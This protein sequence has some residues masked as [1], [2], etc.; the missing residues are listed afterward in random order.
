MD[1]TILSEEDRRKILEWNSHLPD[2]VDALIHE[3]FTA[4]AQRS[5]DAPAIC[6]WDGE[7]NYRDLDR[8]STQLAHHFGDLGVQPEQNH[9]VAIHLPKC[10]WVPVLALAILKAGGICLT[11][12]ISLPPNRLRTVLSQA[13]PRFVCSRSREASTI[14]QGETITIDDGFFERLS[15]PRLNARLPSLVSSRTAYLIFTSGSTGIPKAVLI[16]HVNMCTA[17]QYQHAAMGI[18]ATSRVWDFVSCAFDV[19]YS[20]LFQTLT[21]GACLCIPSEDD[22]VQ[23]PARSVRKLRANYAHITPTI[24]RLLDPSDVP[25]LST[26]NFIGEP[27]TRSDV[28]RWSARTIYNTWGPCECTPVSSIA[29]IDPNLDETPHVGIGFGAVTWVI[30]Q[31]S[32]ELAAIGQ[33]GE[34]VVEG[35]LVGKG[36]LNDPGK[37][38]AAFIPNPVWLPK[39]LPESRLH[40]TFYRTGDLAFYRED[41]NLQ[42]V[43]RSD[44]QIKIAGVR[45]EL[46]EVETHLRALLPQQL[47]VQVTAEKVP[48]EN[49]SD[50]RLVAFFTCPTLTKAELEE[51]LETCRLNDELAKSLPSAMLPSTYVALDAMPTTI[52]GKADRLSLRKIGA[53][54]LAKLIQVRRGDIPSTSEELEM[55]SL[56]QRVLHLKAEDIRTQ[57]SFLDL[58]GSSVQAIRLA[59]EARKRGFELHVGDIL[60]DPRF[61]SMASVLRRSTMHEEAIAP[62]SL[63]PSDYGQSVSNIRQQVAS[64]CSIASEDIT[65]VYPTTSLQEA[66]LA[67]STKRPGDYVAHLEATL[68]DHIDVIHFREAWQNLVAQTPILRTRIINLDG[69]PRLYQVVVQNDTELVEIGL[70]QPDTLESNNTTNIGVGT[71][72][73]KAFLVQNGGIRTFK[74]TISHVI[75][76]GWSISLLLNALSRLY[77]DHSDVPAPSFNLFIKH[78]TDIDY[79]AAE[80]F[81]KQHFADLEAPQFPMLPSPSH[82]VY[83]DQTFARSFNQLR[84]QGSRFTASTLI[85]AAYALLISNYTSH[86]LSEALF[87]AVVAGRQVA[88]PGIESIIGPTFATIPIRIKIDAF[89]TVAHFLES[90]QQGAIATM[91]FEQY[92]LQNIAKLSTEAVQGCQFQSL[93]VV[94][95]GV[96]DRMTSCDL[97]QED[98]ADVSIERISAFST[99]ALTIQCTLQGSTGLLVE[100]SFDSAVVPR[101]QVEKLVAQLGTVLEQLSM[102]T[103]FAKRVAD[104]ATITNEDVQTIQRWNQIELE[105]SEYCIHD[106]IIENAR[107]FPNEEAVCSWDGSL[108]YHQLDEL[109]LALAMHLADIG[110]RPGVAV[111]LCFEKSKWMPV[112]QL[113]IWRA[114][115]CCV[116]LDTSQPLARLRSIVAQV[117]PIVV[118]SSVSKTEV[119][120]KLTDT[121]VSTVSVDMDMISRLHH[122]KLQY[123][124]TSQPSDRLY[125]VYVYTESQGDCFLQANFTSI[126]FTSGSTGEPKGVIISHRNFAYQ[127]Q[128]YGLGREARVLDFSSYAWDAALWNVLYTL[129]VGGCLCEFQGIGNDLIWWLTRT[130]YSI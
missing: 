22:R 47:G 71:Q 129:A 101:S 34:L 1:T 96:E 38:K 35:P 92:G 67:S 62:F 123:L 29:V 27:L 41:G 33:I 91:E 57:D 68:A 66:L 49:G 39:E 111:P 56:W 125:I 80:N 25:D 58:G 74:L 83:A 79:A 3:L 17:I 75:Y 55:Q 61:C 54:R 87:G 105:P 48:L 85:H 114:G 100:A 13:Q 32:N 43:G 28:L 45:I 102:P 40:A 86:E 63:I 6:A 2:P 112:A 103:A 106:R 119:A 115:G 5:P 82:Q 77:H 90:V 60:H 120:Q 14:S 53:D 42:F 109:S 24:G 122:P 84:W 50:P 21:S 95:P 118:I 78:V 89:D 70:G 20:N 107:N 128:V 116:A 117:D 76:D 4:A 16:S 121:A 52:S 130:R 113:A 97:F 59:A 98:L 7:F 126:S 104:I 31:S 93:L 15:T 94:Q 65:D 30:D 81:W 51:V 108:N 19:S 88:I 10:K 124:P 8:L 26:V 127:V 23:N 110:V 12:D 11:L 44:S 37:T 72:L 36:Y 18:T 9:V 64:Q 73:A 69:L 46:G 99:Y